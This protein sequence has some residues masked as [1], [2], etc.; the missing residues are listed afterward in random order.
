M[1]ITVFTPTYNRKELLRRLFTTL[2]NQTS[3]DFEWLIIDDGSTDKT[4][5]IIEQFKKNSDFDIVYIKKDNGGKHTAMNVAFKIARGEYFVCV[6][7]DDYLL[8]DAI[9]KMCDLSEQI[10]HSNLAGFVGMCQDKQGNVIGKAPKRNIIS[11]TIDIRDKYRIKGE[12]EIYRTSILRDKEFPVFDGEKFITEAI[13]FDEISMS[14]K[15]MY[16]NIVMMIKD[17]Q[18]GG[19]TANEPKIRIDN[20]IGTLTYY[21]KKYKL[22]RT[23]KG[24][25]KAAVNFGRFLMHYRGS[26]KLVSS[27]IRENIV[28]SIFSP[29]A[30]IIYLVDRFKLRRSK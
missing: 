27:S 2:D 29:I 25:V 3:N 12:P 17:F 21:R 6:D 26:K 28:I 9:E 13:L 4:E 22:S 11:N 18:E 23:I 8:S 15:L 16:T 30:F 5:D 24:K 10:N 7:S 14:N 20:P 1:K 19:L